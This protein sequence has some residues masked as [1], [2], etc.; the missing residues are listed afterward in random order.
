MDR[1]NYKPVSCRTL[2][3]GHVYR[4]HFY[5]CLHTLRTRI[6]IINSECQKLYSSYKILLVNTSFKFITKK[7][8]STLY[9]FN[10]TRSAREKS[11]IY[12]KESDKVLL[13][14]RY[15]LIVIHHALKSIN[16]TLHRNYHN[17]MYTNYSIH[18]QKLL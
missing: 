10:R 8:N 17:T 5:Y 14:F 11:F 18:E 4:K 1:I 12:Q 13:M 3:D 2:F 9:K 15:H 7:F 6:N 16:F